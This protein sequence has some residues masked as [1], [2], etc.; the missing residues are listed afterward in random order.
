MTKIKIRVIDCH[1][2]Y[3]NDKKSDWELRNRGIQRKYSTYLNK[4]WFAKMMVFVDFGEF[5]TGTRN[6]QKWW[7]AKMMVLRMRRRRAWKWWFWSLDLQSSVFFHPAHERKWQASSGKCTSTTSTK[8][9]FEGR[10][11][12]C[13][14]LNVQNETTFFPGIVH[15]PMASRLVTNGPGCFNNTFWTIIFH[16]FMTWPHGW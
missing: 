13:K 3:Y 16:F 5:W 10:D 4:W 11:D 2:A 12:C 14:L 6:S 8:R 15:F 1:I 7:F 9:K